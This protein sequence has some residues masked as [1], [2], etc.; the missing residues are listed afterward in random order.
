MVLCLQAKCIATQ[1]KATFFN[2]TAGD[3]MSKYHGE[4]PKLQKALFAKARKLP[5]SVIFIGSLAAHH[6]FAMLD[7]SLR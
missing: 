3:L 5:P 6:I 2:V 7:S 1:A 4:G